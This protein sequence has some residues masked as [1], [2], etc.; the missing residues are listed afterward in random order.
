M[1]QGGDPLGNGTGGPGYSFHDEFDPSL[2][3]DGPGVLSMANSGPNTNGSQFFITH[4]E[5]PWLDGKHSIFG[6]V[7][8]GQDVVNAIKQGDTIKTIRIVR[9]GAGAAAFQPDQASFEKLEAAAGKSAVEKS[10][11]ALGA[12]ISKIEAKYPKASKSASGI[13]YVINKQGSGEKPQKGQKVSTNY[14]LTLLSGQVVDDSGR[15][16][17]PLEFNAGSGQVIPGWDEMILDMRPGENRTV[18]IPPEL[19]YG[20]RGAGNGLI[21]PNSFLEFEIELLK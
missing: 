19:G 9:N 5:T 2:R 16:G 21:P 3:H 8:R 11:A 20:E 12:E 18:V 7:A 17:K 15:H 6:R 13:W 10:N 4:K 14:K 1:I